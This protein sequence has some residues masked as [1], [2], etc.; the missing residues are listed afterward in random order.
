MRI[1]SR[2]ASS[3]IARK[4]FSAEVA[5]QCSPKNVSALRASM[6][7]LAWKKWRKAR[8]LRAMAVASLSKPITGPARMTRERT[9]AGNFRIAASVAALN[10]F[11]ATKA[12]TWSTLDGAASAA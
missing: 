9:V 2:C 3:E 5:I 8:R 1:T 6:A 4:A 7:P 11:V 12:A 10:L